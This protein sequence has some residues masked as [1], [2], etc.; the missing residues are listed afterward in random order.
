[1]QRALMKHAKD[2]KIVLNTKFWQ[3]FNRNVQDRLWQ[4][5]NPG[6]IRKPTEGEIRHI[7]SLIDN[8]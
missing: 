3:G 6:K 1:M 5:M 4:K 2:N 8:E 7:E